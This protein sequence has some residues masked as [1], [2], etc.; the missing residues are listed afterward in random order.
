MRQPPADFLASVDSATVVPGQI[1]LWYTGGAGYVLRTPG[2]TVYLD[3]FTGPS[4]EKWVR[5]V[6]PAF[7]PRRV[8]RCDLILSTHDHRDHCDPDALGPLLAGTAAPLAG[9]D[10]SI[11]VARGIGW[12]EAR[13]RTL[14]HG[15]TLECGDLR[16]TTVRS[17]DPLAKG[18]NGYVIEA[19]GIVFV[20]MG[21]SLWYDEIG[22]ELGRWS[23]DA[24]AVSVAQNPPGETY[25]MSEV[26]AAR[27]AR[28]VGARVL[29]PH[30]WDLWQWVSLDPRRVQAVA[31]W[32][33]P[34]AQVR[35]ARYCERM[36]LTRAGAALAVECAPGGRRGGCFAAG[37]GGRA[38]GLARL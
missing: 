3:P 1:A 10:A 34:D 14:G 18:A 37:A 2:T 24:I 5:G 33:A 31:P 25:Y 36:T 28:D 30:H 8:R 22:Q 26:D 29:I 7:D 13:L 17:R 15:D 38:R 35:P 12:P 21:D 6:A 19:E 9:P 27:I 11:A 16:L 20:T 4:D 32:Y 23:V